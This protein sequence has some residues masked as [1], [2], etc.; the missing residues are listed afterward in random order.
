[1]SKIYELEEQYKN[2]KDAVKKRREYYTE[3][4]GNNHINN[5]PYKHINYDEIYNVC[6]D[7]T[8]GYIP[9]PIGM[10]GPLT[11]NSQQHYIPLATTEGC[12]IASIQ[13]G[14]KCITNGIRSV[15]VNDCMTR[16]PVL[17]FNSLIDCVKFREWF[18][19][20]EEKIISKFNETSNH[21]R[22]QKISTK[23]VARMVYM[24]FVAFTGNAMGMNICTK[25]VEN[26]LEYIK[27]NF[28]AKIVSISSN[29]CI[30]K[31]N[32]AINWIEGR[33]K[34]VVA[35]TIISKDVI[36]NVLKTDIDSLCELNTYK[37]YI[38]SS[39]AVSIGGNN[40]HAAN[41]V[42]GIFAA[43]GQDLAQVVESSNCLTF[44]EKDGENLYMSCTMPSLEVGTI[45]GGTH[46]TFQKECLSIMGVNNIKDV[47]NTKKFAEIISGVVLA[48]ELSLLAALNTDDLTKSHMKF[49]RKKH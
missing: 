27:E 29:Y 37:N 36:E 11:V 5:I 13:R 10:V 28:N 35:E 22:L 47:N 40:C 19:I 1:M 42:V 2:K 15:V 24:R 17:K 26:V 48:G 45:G 7:N 18:E 31:K 9:I 34:S 14:I 12:L 44:L 32:S 21:G 49:N 38:G 41:I 43:T 30:D 39:L 3:K 20:N 8:I 16:A 6:C 46:L 25:G 33:G 4:M 23:I